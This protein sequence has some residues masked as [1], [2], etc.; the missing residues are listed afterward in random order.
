MIHY[1]QLLYEYA[2][3]SKRNEET[4]GKMER[5]TVMKMEKAGIMV[6]NILL[7][8]MMIDKLL[9]TKHVSFT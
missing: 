2:L 8:M 1:C 4:K 6:Q 7:L 9:K 5:Q 3:T